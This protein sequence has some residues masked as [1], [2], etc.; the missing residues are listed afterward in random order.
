MHRYSF[1]A[2]AVCL[3]M[4]STAFSQDPKPKA[5]INHVALFVMSCKA[6]AAF[7]HEVVGL[8]TIPEPFHDGKHVWMAIGPKQS[9]HIIE[10]STAKKEYYKNNHIC[11]TVPS[12]EAFTEILKKRN[13][14]F[15][16][17]AGNKGK[18][19]TRVDKVKQLWLQDPDGYWLEINDAKE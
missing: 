13:I 4:S 10:G 16:D 1:V 8:D 14:P 19:T 18:I 2:I 5:S 11:F 6:T 3:L 12:V 9:M 7:Y 17:V 15:E